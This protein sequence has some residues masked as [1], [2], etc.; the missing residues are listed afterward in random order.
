[1]LN[2]KEATALMSQAQDRPL[3]RVERLR[4][5]LHLLFCRGCRRFNA[6]MTF[7]RRAITRRSNTF[8]EP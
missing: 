7:L 2:C 6:H 4:L 3:G 8:K 1:M 5:R